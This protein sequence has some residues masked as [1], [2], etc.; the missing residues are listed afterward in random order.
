MGL[1]SS[2]QVIFCLGETLFGGIFVG[3][4]ILE[5][6]PYAKILRSG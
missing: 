2:L 4:E 6:H 1:G 3:W 5:S